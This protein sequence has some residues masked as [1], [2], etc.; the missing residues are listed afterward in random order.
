[1]ARIAQILYK[2]AEKGM[3]IR[4]G[5]YESIAQDVGGDP[6][7]VKRYF[8]GQL[9]TNTQSSTKAQDRLKAVGDIF[10]ISAGTTTE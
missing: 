10:G 7:F 1:M 4:R 2:Q 6:N 9:Q 5:T 8:D 3:A